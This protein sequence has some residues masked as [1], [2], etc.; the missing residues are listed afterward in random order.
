MKKLKLFALLAIVV[1]ILT[2]CRKEYYTVVEYGSQV[3]T[4]EYTV[5]PSDWIL[6][7]GNYEPGSEN[8]LY[9]KVDNPDITPD[10][11]DNGTVT[12]DIYVLYD[13]QKK[14]GSWC[15]LPYVYPLEVSVTNDDGTPGYII[16]GESIR[17]EWVKGMVTFVIQ[18]LDGYDPE[19]MITSVTIRVTVVKNLH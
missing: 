16:V 2:G 1:T 12:A 13:E 10:V 4:Y 6:N 18:D 17:M 7:E 11:L 5:K 19:D 14:L 9:Y 8:Y 3:L 15:P